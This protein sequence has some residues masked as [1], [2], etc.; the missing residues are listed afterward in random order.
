MPKFKSLKTDFRI[1]SNRT[2]NGAPLTYLDSASTTQKPKSVIDAISYFYEN[3]SANIHR[4]VYD[5]SQESTTQ[6]EETREAVRKFINAKSSE[7]IIFTRGATEAINLVAYSYGRKHIKKDDNIVVSSLEHHSN[8]V[9]WQL[10]A[11]ETGAELR[12]MPIITQGPK[13]GLIDEQEA[14]KLIDTKTK[15]VAV[16]GASNVLGTITP[17]KKLAQL[18]HQV[19]AKILVDGAQSVPHL[20]TDVQAIDCDFLAFSS[21]KMLGPTG[22]GVLYGKKEILEEMPPFLTG[23]DMIRSVE[24]YTATWNDLPHKFEAGTP[25]IEGVIAFKKAIEYIEALDDGTSKGMEVITDHDQNLLTYAREK[26]SQLPFVT[27]YGPED[28]TKCTGVLSFNVNGVHPHDTAEILNNF[29]VCI[30]SGHHCCE[31]LMKRLNLTATARMSFYL[32]NEEQDIDRA[33]EALREVAKIF[34]K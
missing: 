12:V 28:T 10:L 2:K 27:L 20:S 7:E 18:A 17:V 33:V 30:R 4:G 1:F 32:Y 25:N 21:H 9:P 14:E 31:P 26:L 6:Y 29:N 23:G 5:L 16:T 11:Q 8:L 22:V 19:G 3:R 34:K 24:Q 15:I 13:Q